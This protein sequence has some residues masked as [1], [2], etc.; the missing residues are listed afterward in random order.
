MIIPQTLVYL[1]GLYIH[2]LRTAFEE[3]TTKHAGECGVQLSVGAEMEAYDD[4][5]SYK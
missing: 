4:L 5:S 1:P 2:S 3:T